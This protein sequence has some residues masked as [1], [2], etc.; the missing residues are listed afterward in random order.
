MGKV[1]IF[2]I[3]CDRQS[4]FSTYFLPLISW[5]VRG[6]LSAHLS[7]P[8]NWYLLPNHHT[9][10]YVTFY[11][12]I[13]VNCFKSTWMG[14]EMALIGRGLIPLCLLTSRPNA[15][16]G[17]WSEHFTAY[18]TQSPI[19]NKRDVKYWSIYLK[20]TRCLDKHLPLLSTLP[21][22]YNRVTLGTENE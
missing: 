18:I 6:L 16:G 11:V 13:N 15:P 19:A 4:S 5:Q 14:A 8:C 22:L 21:G 12:R 20:S 17:L 7:N 9:S 2:K 1:R 3:I 10:V